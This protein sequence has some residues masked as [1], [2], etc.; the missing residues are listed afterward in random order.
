[1][2]HGEANIIDREPALAR[3]GPASRGAAPRGL[4]PCTPLP[5]RPVQE[6]DPQGPLTTEPPPADDSGEG[7]FP[8]PPKSRLSDYR[9]PRLLAAL[10]FS[11]IVHIAF[12]AILFFAPHPK[13][14]V[15]PPPQVVVLEFAALGKPEAPEVKPEP[16]P[17]PPEAK[18]PEPA[19]PPA[20]PEPLPEIKAQPIPETPPAKAPEPVLPAPAQAKP[21]P[22]KPKPPEPP[23]VEAPP[24]PAAPPAPTPEPQ[25]PPVAAAPTPSPASAPPTT[26]TPRKGIE[27]GVAS[28][29]S[30]TE[31]SRYV[32]TLFTMIDAKKQYPPQSMQR[33]EEGTVVIRLKIA[34]DGTLIDVTSPTTDPHRLVDASLEAV[35]R[36]APFPALPASLG[37]SEA[38]FEVPV[39]YK[40]Q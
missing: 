30:Q 18:A 40:L 27:T 28:G 14:I 37:K 1:M 25:A 2:M 20:P 19:P 35:R 5:I 15:Q 29:T 17:P 36:A 4:A 13:P 34:A 31:M 7:N 24:A 32:T 16:P 22:R 26:E 10:A 21:R 6:Q 33:R 9:S 8:I 11:A 38:E 3:P 12:F 39:N 23:K